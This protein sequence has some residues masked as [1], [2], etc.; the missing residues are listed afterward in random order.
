ML[1]LARVVTVLVRVSSGSMRR[2]MTASAVTVAVA[3]AAVA[4]VA[5]AVAVRAA[6]LPQ[7]ADPLLLMRAGR[8]GGVWVT[9]LCST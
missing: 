3:A 2:S 5:S 6:D 4:A 9:I 7:D 1:V 8:F